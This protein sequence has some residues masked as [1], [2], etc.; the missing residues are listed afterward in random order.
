MLKD[1]VRERLIAVADEIFELFERTIASYEEQ[2]C[3][4]REENERH[5]RRLEAF[6]INTPKEAPP[7]PRGPPARVKREEDEDAGKLPPTADEDAAP[8]SSR[9]R[10]PRGGPAPPPDALLAPLSDSDDGQTAP[11]GDA[12]RGAD[13]NARRTGTRG[14][15]SRP[16]SFTCG[17]CAKS[18]TYKCNLNTHMR[19]HNAEKPFVC[20]VCGKRFSQKVHMLSHMR[21]H[22]GE[23]PFTCS[24]CGVSYP[25]KLSLTVHM[26]THTGEKPFFCSVCG[27]RFSLKSTMVSHTRIHTGEK[28]FR[29][30]VCGNSFSR[31]SSMVS[32]MRTHTGE[33]P[34]A[35][36]DEALRQ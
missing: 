9:L 34:F 12:D 18:F 22:T 28:P 6:S 27:K 13:G 35:C 24:L 17:V 29:C 33:K 7:R 15:P 25:Y 32:H 11:N 30:A 8:R 21:T 16:G 19:T 26:R 2:L 36:S 1:L 4:A 20:S 14:A 23:K 10:R 5:R 31:K 3:R